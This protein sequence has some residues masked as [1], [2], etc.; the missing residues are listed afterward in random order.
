MELQFRNR[1][2]IEILEI[3]KW[4]FQTKATQLTCVLLW[5]FVKTDG[6][7][8]ATYEFEIFYSLFLTVLINANAHFGHNS[9]VDALD[10]H[11]TLTI[12]ASVL[13]LI[14]C[15]YLRHCCCQWQ[16]DNH[17]WQTTTTS[18]AAI[19]TSCHTSES[20]GCGCDCG[21][22]EE[23]LFGTAHQQS[24]NSNFLSYIRKWRL[25]LWL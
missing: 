23:N 6:G 7:P 19:A 9:P 22:E 15:C 13:L 18:N 20:G 5:T 24:C 16:A 14:S 8:I 10:A 25:R 12:V 4:F 3:R 11:C 17:L 2:I 1:D 21:T